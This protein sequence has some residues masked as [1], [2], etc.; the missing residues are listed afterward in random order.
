MNTFHH[1][2]ITDRQTG[3]SFPHQNYCGSDREA[4]AL[5]RLAW[6]NPA[7]WDITNVQEQP[8]EC[9]APNLAP[10]PKPTPTPVAVHPAPAAA[11]LALF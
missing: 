4:I 10:P 6:S 2:T 11:Q 9:A 1:L 8:A 3:D 5:A 7:L